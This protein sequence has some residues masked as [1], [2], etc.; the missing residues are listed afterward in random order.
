MWVDQSTI[1]S[2]PKLFDHTV[3][4]VVDQKEIIGGFDRGAV[5]HGQF[6]SHG[7]VTP[8]EINKFLHGRQ[9][10]L[11]RSN[12]FAHW[13]KGGKST[14]ID[15]DVCSWNF[16]NVQNGVDPL[17]GVRMRFVDVG[18]HRVLRRRRAA[19]LLIYQSGI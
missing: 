15:T 5:G 8:G 14:I 9:I 3:R 4:K 16:E 13:A 17:F 10:K 11:N 12:T 18:V 2:H 7:E 1:E 19:S 6:E